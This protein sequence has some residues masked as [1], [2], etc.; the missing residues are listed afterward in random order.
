MKK[1]LVIIL[2]IVATYFIAKDQEL[3][4]DDITT[5]T[6]NR[7]VEIWNDSC[8]FVKNKAAT[9]WNNLTGIEETSSTEE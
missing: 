8:S 5:S 1:I 4:S 6:E 7:V 3:I 9:V 2:I